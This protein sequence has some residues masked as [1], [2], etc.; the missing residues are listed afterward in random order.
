MESSFF[1]KPEVLKSARQVLS[2]D[3]VITV[4]ATVGISVIHN[5]LAQNANIVHWLISNLFVG[6]ED[7]RILIDIVLKESDNK[8]ITRLSID[9]W[10]KKNLCDLTHKE[11]MSNNFYSL[12]HNTVFRCNKAIIRKDYL[13]PIL[14]H[15]ADEHYKEEV[16]SII[17]T[18]DF[19]EML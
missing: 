9:N 11:K 3:F 10:P 7:G 15:L 5:I 12:N 18:F 6:D 17:S 13:I 16:C 14:I 8:A 19:N 1:R 4:N 2:G